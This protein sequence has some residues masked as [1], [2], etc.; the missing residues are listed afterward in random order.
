MLV[1][2]DINKNLIIMENKKSFRRKFALIAG[3]AVAAIFMFET[4]CK[5]YDPVITPKKPSGGQT[6]YFVRMTDA[7]GN[8]TAVNVDIQSVVVKTNRGDVTLN[9]NPGIYN[10][11]DFT[12][13]KDTLI[14]TGGLDSA[15][16]SQ[17]RLVLGSN[18][19]VVIDSVTYPLE[20]PSGA[21][22]G[23]K[24]QVHHELKAGVAY[25]VLLDFDA[26]KSVVKAGKKYLLK[27]VIRT[28]DSAV[29]GS[30]KGLLFPAGVRTDI[31]AASG[32]D[33]FRITA[34]VTGYFLFKGIPS[35]NYNLEFT[36]DTPYNVFNVNG[37]TVTN[38]QTT[39]LGTLNL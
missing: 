12:N 30:I 31:S 1:I 29:S 20:V 4:G 35:G 18:N 6:N 2:G 14:A 34:D 39:N 25:T 36:P 22:S 16:V 21:Q 7:P 32:T 11:L 23:L 15:V 10:L 28:I 24:L 27:P 13:G 33:T 5:K 17:I 9:V 3:V 38:G 26:A 8:F 19:T 37:V